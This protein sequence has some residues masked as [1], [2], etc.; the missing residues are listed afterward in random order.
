[1]IHK[2]TRLLIYYNKLRIAWI[3]LFFSS[4]QDLYSHRPLPH[5]IGTA[6]FL[7]DETLGLEEIHTDDED[8]AEKADSEDNEDD[9]TDESDS[10]QESEE[11]VCYFFL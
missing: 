9:E 6:E 1:M 8:E 5:L 11:E 3:S 7:H 4:E 10:D 2:I